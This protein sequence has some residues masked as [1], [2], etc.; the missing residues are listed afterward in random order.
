MGV[1]G[2]VVHGKPGNEALDAATLGTFPNVGVGLLVITPVQPC[3]CDDGVMAEDDEFDL[4]GL[5][6]LATGAGEN[7]DAS[8]GMACFSNGGADAVVGVGV[9]VGWA[10]D[11]VEIAGDG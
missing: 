7:E 11:V 5:G 4:V 3:C 10:E 2:G 8:A 9:G 1:C 6:G